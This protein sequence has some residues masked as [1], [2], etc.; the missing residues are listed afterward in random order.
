MNVSLL[1][2]KGLKGLINDFQDVETL[3]NLNYRDVHAVKI[4][5]LQRLSIG[6]KLNFWRL[7]NFQGAQIR[8]L[9]DSLKIKDT[10][11][12]RSKYP[13]LQGHREEERGHAYTFGVWTP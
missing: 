12:L 13:R 4:R 5:I 2:T 9:K 11:S 7:S 6:A 3:Q 10:K 1:R 8:I